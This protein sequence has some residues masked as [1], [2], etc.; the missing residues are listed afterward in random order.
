MALQVSDLMTRDPVTLVPTSSLDELFDLMETAN[1]RH[2]PVVDESGALV[3]VASHRDLVRGA[4]YGEDEL[5][6]S[7]VRQMLRERTVGEIMSKE[8]QT[9]SSDDSIDTAGELILENKFGCLPVV[10]GEGLVG[11]LTPLDFVKYLTEQE[12]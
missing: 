11:I 12:R 4:L 6:V 8:P 7:T 5:P 9:V 1:V 2:I 3:G 10:D